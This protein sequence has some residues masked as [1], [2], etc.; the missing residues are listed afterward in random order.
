MR[1]IGTAATIVA[2]DGVLTAMS[3]PGWK[4]SPAIGQGPDY[5]Y[6]H[7]QQARLQLPDGQSIPAGLPT[8]WLA[9]WGVILLAAAADLIR[10][11]P[12]VVGES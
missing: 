11:Q 7:M 2:H 3:T 8:A 10:R 5:F 6:R 4:D 12:P 1:E 9:V